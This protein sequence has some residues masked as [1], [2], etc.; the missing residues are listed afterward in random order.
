MTLLVD[1]ELKARTHLLEVDLTYNNISLLVQNSIK[2]LLQE[3]PYALRYEN[4]DKE[5]R[6]AT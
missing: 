1:E 3:T 6:V 5:A 2:K 4:I